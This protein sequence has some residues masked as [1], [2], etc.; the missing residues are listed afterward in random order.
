MTVKLRF[1]RAGDKVRAV[2]GEDVGGDADEFGL[3]GACRMRYARARGAGEGGE[4][5]GIE[6]RDGVRESV[7]VSRRGWVGVGP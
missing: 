1:Q 4:D 3:G 6:C 7:E 5:I 2:G